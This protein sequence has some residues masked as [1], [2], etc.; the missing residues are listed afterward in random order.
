MAAILADLIVRPTSADIRQTLASFEEFLK[1]RK[2]SPLFRLRTAADIHRSL[3]FFNTGPYQ[4]AGLI[5]M[6]LLAGPRI[7]GGAWSQIVVLFNGASYAQAFAH[8][9][10]VGAPLAL[11][12]IQAASRNPITCSA[13]FDAAGGAFSVPAYTTAVFVGAGRPN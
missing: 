2:S 11:H 5:V 3:S 12:P 10:F 4:S 9:T 7:D 13:A 1:I 8:P 6:R